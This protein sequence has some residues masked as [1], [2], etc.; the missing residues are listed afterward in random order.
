MKTFMAALLGGMFIKFL[1]IGL[2]VFLLM[3]F[4]DLDLINFLISFL[5]FY[6]VYQCYEFRFLN[7]KLAKGKK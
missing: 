2:I 4:T 5:G 3:K 6:F 1:L 7:L